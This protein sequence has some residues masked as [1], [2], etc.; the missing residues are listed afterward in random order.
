MKMNSTS[1]HRICLFVLACIFLAL[2]ACKRD[3]PLFKGDKRI[4]SNKADSAMSYVGKNRL[5]ISFTAPDTSI[6]N[7]TIFWNDR[8][9]SLAIPIS[10]TA[11]TDTVSTLIEPLDEGDYVFEII[12]SDAKG[13]RS[14]PVKVSGKVYGSQYIQSLANRPIRDIFYEDG[15]AVILWEHAAPAEVTTEV[16]Y[17]DVDNVEHKKQVPAV[18]D[19]TKLLNLKP[20]TLA[21]A[22]QYHT[23]YVPDLAIDTFFADSKTQTVITGNLK[24]LANAKNILFGSLISFGRSGVTDGV[25]YDG[26]PNGIYTDFCNGEFNV[27][28]ATWGPSR[29]SITGP[30]DFNEVNAVINWSKQQYDKV[31]AMLIVGPNNYMPSW[32]TTGNFTPEEMDVMLK[33]LITEIM[34][35]NDNKSKVDVWCVANEL[36]NEDGT[37]RTMKWNDMGW[38]EDASGLTGNDQINLKHPV[39]VGKAFQYCRELTNALLELRD[40]GIENNDP[41]NP[42][43]FKYKA[44]YQLVKHL[45]ATNR[46]L[47]VVG[48]QSHIMIGKGTAVGTAANMNADVPAQGYDGFKQAIKRYKESG[49]DVYLTELDIVSLLKSGQP[50]PWTAALATQQKTDYYNIIKAAV[51]SGVN[52]ISLWGARDNNDIGW[53][54]DQSPLL[55]D[56]YY[57][58]KPAYYGV[59]KALFDLK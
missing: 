41:Q 38:E 47:D 23:A 13:H 12:T 58:R 45:Q 6:V 11:D 7:A 57:H 9:D 25:I 5:K 24:N 56:Q 15:A 53:R 19:S 3:E 31:M 44:F 55:L 43:L 18:A 8:K 36:F 37:Y 17:T 59:Q 10:K 30:S 16:T 27:G 26:S 33:N 20:E 35:S 42:F 22:I 4:Y 14:I 48:I 46:P 2:N 28:Q 49:L 51:E 34:N 54:L 32:F 39:F 40:Y 52:L 50:Q 29:W 21:T 1:Y